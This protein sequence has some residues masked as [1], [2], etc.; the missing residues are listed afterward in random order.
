MKHIFSV[1]RSSSIFAPSCDG[2]FGSVCPKSISK[3]TAVSGVY[4]LISCLMRFF[5]L[6]TSWRGSLI[7]LPISMAES[8][9]S[10]PLSPRHISYRFRGFLRVL[11]LMSLKRAL[12]LQYL[13]D[14]AG[15]VESPSANPQYRNSHRAVFFQSCLHQN[16]KTS[17]QDWGICSFHPLSHPSGCP[18]IH[19]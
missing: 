17:S 6:S 2:S 8:C 18:Q 12:C 14:L 7:G 1:I 3:M 16:S 13:R 19:Q 4:L 11:L 15:I 10:I 5:V 9:Y